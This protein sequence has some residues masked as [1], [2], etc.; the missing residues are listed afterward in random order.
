MA[1]EVTDPKI[2][3]CVMD[4][5][6]CCLLCSIHRQPGVRA[7]VDKAESPF[8]HVARNGK[9][10]DIPVRGTKRS[11]SS[12]GDESEDIWSQ[13]SLFKTNLIDFRGGIE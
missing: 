10:D 2:H 11:R 1:S 3:I 7:Y 4:H 13:I 6:M 12:V 9:A 5:G 8:R